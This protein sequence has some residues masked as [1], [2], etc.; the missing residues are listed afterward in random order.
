MEQQS[1]NKLE[2]L[3]EVYNRYGHTELLNVM[4]IRDVGALN[5]SEIG[6]I[7]GITRERVRQIEKVAL[8]KLKHPKNGR[9]LK[10]YIEDYSTPDMTTVD[11]GRGSESQLLNK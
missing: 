5:L 9:K 10:Q 1:K 3:K 2:V 4:S 11:F 7:L 6:Y 8:I